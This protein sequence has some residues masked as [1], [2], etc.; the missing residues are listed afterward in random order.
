[1][2]KRDL[3]ILF[4]A[5]LLLRLPFLN[6]AVQGDDPMFLA[7][8]SHALID[9]LHPNH[10]H[11]IFTSVGEDVDFRGNP[12][13]PMNAWMLAAL[14]AIF[15]DVQEIPFHAA[16]IGL[17]LLAVLAMYSLARR[18]SPQPLL[19]SLL[20]LAVPAFVVNGGSF[21][22]DVPHLAFFIAG[23]AAFIR[24]V[25]RRSVQWL[26]L[27]ALAISL[28]ALTVIQAQLAM[29]ILLLYA[30]LHGRDWK[31]AW[32]TPFAAI[33]TLVAWEIFER[34]TTGVFPFMVTAGYVREQSWD[35]LALKLRSAVELSIH[36]WFMI[37][38]LLLAA[39]LY[40]AWRQRNR[41][42]AFLAGW[43]AIYL[44][45]CFV[46]FFSGSARYLLPLAAPLA[47]LAS[48]ARRSWVVAGFAIQMTLSLGLATAN[49]QQWDAYRDFSKSL[50]SQA[51]GHRVWVNSEWGLRHY[52]EDAGARVPLGPQRI[53]PGDI[54]VWSELAA[55]VAV[56]HPGAIA[57][58]VMQQDVRPSM[59]FRLIAL[60]SES[61]YSDGNRGY[62]PYG[63]GTGLVDRIHAD[64]YKEV[65]PTLTDLPMNAPEA[66]TQIVSGLFGLEEGKQRWTAG[67]ATVILVSPPDAEP[68]HIDLYVPDNAPAREMTVLLDGRKVYT[69][70]IAPG[71]LSLLTPPQKAAGATS[72]VSLQLDRTFSAPGDSRVLGVR[73]I[74]I[75]WGK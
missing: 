16:Y 34:L 18:F 53:P 2:A 31:P 21:E 38:P 63:I 17:S 74:R 69:Q 51:G 22:A 24:G 1:L 42:T 10:T 32:V 56:S 30:W 50:M 67:T 64:T 27:S 60:E 65:K 75:G 4:A 20:F 44:A 49:Y 13:P 45:G 28:A 54:V 68:L 39:G 14:L 72:V 8:A 71:M 29:P 12:H 55:P 66:E 46:L 9:P 35:R 15:G 70:A 26:A 33:A 36:F 23:M 59:P 58:S 61:G 57:A 40:A 41:D 73:L 19:A 5:V 7:S 37:F 52:L 62:F 6:E 25:D 3:L 43:I 47:I 11:Y 48:F